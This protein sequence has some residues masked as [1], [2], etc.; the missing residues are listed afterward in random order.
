M[1]N[2]TFTLLNLGENPKFAL[3]GA[4][5]LSIQ[6]LEELPMP[7]DSCQAPRSHLRV[8]KHHPGGKFRALVVGDRLLS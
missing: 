8:D 7:F 3:L 4:E 1:Y 6:I 5:R 2:S